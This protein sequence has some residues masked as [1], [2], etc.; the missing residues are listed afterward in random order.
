MNFITII[1]I[2]LNMN[3][4]ATHGRLILPFYIFKAVGNPHGF[5][6]V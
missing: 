5:F 2:G 6:F 1:G 4:G 3:I